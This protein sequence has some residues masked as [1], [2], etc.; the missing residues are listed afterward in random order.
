MKSF[1]FYLEF[2]RIDGLSFII[3]NYILFEYI[4]SLIY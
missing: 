3:D 4:G 1:V 2:S